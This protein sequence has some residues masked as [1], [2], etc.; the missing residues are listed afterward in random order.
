MSAGTEE[1]KTN[2]G[3]GYPTFIMTKQ[4]DCNRSFPILSFL[5]LQMCVSSLVLLVDLE[6]SNSILF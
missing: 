5:Y 3:Y 6:K 4:I 2:L 1:G